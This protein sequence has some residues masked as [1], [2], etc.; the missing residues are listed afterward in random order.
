[1][2]YF[3]G[4]ER[5]EK[6]RELKKTAKTTTDGAL[7]RFDFNRQLLLLLLYIA[8]LY[9]L[10]LAAVAVAHAC[11]SDL[12]AEHPK[13]ESTSKQKTDN[14]EA[15]VVQSTVTITITPNSQHEVNKLL[16]IFLLCV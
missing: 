12:T 1:M 15:A 11:S 7:F 8:C 16:L 10:Q 9:S 4:I 13:N 3:Q 2:K 6:K 5:E 14:I